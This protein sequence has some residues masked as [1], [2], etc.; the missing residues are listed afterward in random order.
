MHS[1]ALGSFFCP[2]VQRKFCFVF[3]F[4][5][6][7]FSLLCPR[8]VLLD[9]VGLDLFSLAISTFYRVIPVSDSSYRLDSEDVSSLFVLIRLQFFSGSFLGEGG[10]FICIFKKNVRV[11]DGLAHRR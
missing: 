1:V 2:T 3:V 10:L 6:I 9:F 7:F 4:F 8:L 11:G 5:L